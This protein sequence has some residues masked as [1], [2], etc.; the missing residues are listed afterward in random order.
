MARPRGDD[1]KRQIVLATYQCVALK[2]VEGTSIR[3]I[4]RMTGLSTGTITYH[5]TSKQKLLLFAIEY[6]YT[7]IPESLA[8][9]NPG[10][11]MQNILQRYELTTPRRRQFWQFWLAITAYAEEEP[12]IEKY[13][14]SVYANALE[15]VQR[16]LDYGQKHGMFRP[17]MDTR[18]EAVRLSALAHGFAVMQLMDRSMMDTAVHELRAAVRRLTVE[19]DVGETVHGYAQ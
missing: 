17:D 15:H 4:A 19:G 14:A 3:E 7:R 10:V 18:T 8:D 12:A 1:V 11:Q 13:L 9:D 2:G 6:G 5:F 16:G